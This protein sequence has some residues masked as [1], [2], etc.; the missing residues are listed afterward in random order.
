MWKEHRQN[1][2]ITMPSLSG[3]LKQQVKPPD[4]Q[5]KL[6]VQLCGHG[7]LFVLSKR[8]DL[9]SRLPE[10]FVVSPQAPASQR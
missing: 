8:A 3:A 7:V 1:P 5:E 2:C 4:V 6:Q 10:L 9:V